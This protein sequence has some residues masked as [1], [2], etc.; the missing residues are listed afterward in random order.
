MQVFLHMFLKR[1]IL[2]S[3]VPNRTVGLVVMMSGAIYIPGS[4]DK[5]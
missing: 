2:Y 1:D 4:L 3:Y 5:A